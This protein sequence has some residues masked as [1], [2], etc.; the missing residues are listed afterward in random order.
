MFFFN[1]KRKGTEAH[2]HRPSCYALTLIQGSMWK[3]AIIQLENCSSEQDYCTGSTFLESNLLNHL[4][5]P[6]HWVSRA[7]SKHSSSAHYWINHVYH[8]I[9]WHTCFKHV[10][11]QHLI[12]HVY[13]MIAISIIIINL[14]NCLRNLTMRA[15]SMKACLYL[16]TLQGGN[17]R[18]GSAWVGGFFMMIEVTHWL[19]LF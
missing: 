10:S 6:C 9:I 3:H 5:P 19:W 2:T 4:T 7:P 1:K 17:I 18:L 15:N 11:A 14:L 13:I 12:N 8:L 16:L